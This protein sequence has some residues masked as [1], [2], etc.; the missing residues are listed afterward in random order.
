[1]FLYAYFLLKRFHTGYCLLKINKH[2][3]TF[4]L[5]L[6]QGGSKVFSYFDRMKTY[7]FIFQLPFEYSEKKES[8]A[9]ADYKAHFIGPFI[10]QIQAQQNGE[11]DEKIPFRPNV[12]I[13]A[14]QDIYLISLVNL[15]CVQNYE[16]ESN[17]LC[18]ERNKV[19]L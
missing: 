17:L 2:K 7:I 14:K 1:M 16:N 10:P 4:S 13:P 9:R 5:M 19:K 8:C 11:N 3:G 12:N 18:K 6:T 15:F